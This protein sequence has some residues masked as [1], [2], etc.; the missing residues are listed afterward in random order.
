MDDAVYGMQFLNGT[1]P[2]MIE[3]CTRLPDNF[4][5]TH[6]LV[7]NFLDRGRTLEEEIKVN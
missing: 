7:E 1:N 3:R 6:Q 5:V 4:P 2:M